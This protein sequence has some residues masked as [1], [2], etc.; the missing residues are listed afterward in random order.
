MHKLP[1]PE[2]LEWTAEEA[3]GL[4][5]VEGTHPR[6]AG[7]RICASYINYYVG[8]SAIVLP[9]FGDR[10]DRVAQATLAEL[11][12]THRIIGIGNSREILL[13]GGNVACITMP[14]YAGGARP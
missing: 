5:Q 11:F 9:L 2:A 8:N 14:Q 6:Q 3:A 12:P 13:G 4:D 10:N 1:Q 7:T